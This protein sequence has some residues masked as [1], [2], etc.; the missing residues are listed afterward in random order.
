MIAVL[1]KGTSQEQTD[2][3][4]NWLKR[5]NLD[6]HTSCGQEVTVLGLIGDTSRV[7]IELLNSLEI[8]ESVKRVSEPFKQANRKFHPKDTVIEMAYET[9]DCL[10]L[11]RSEIFKG[12]LN[13]LEVCHIG[14][15]LT[16][17]NII[18]VNIIEIRYPTDLFRCRQ[19]QGKTRR[20]TNG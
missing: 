4:I 13:L 3:L 14:K 2:H 7:D 20:R 18:F 12:I 9:L 19:R 5:M 8:I 17:I 11:G 6:V 1:K 10:A 16:G 15:Q